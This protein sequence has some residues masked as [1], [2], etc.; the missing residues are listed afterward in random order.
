MYQAFLNKPW[1]ARWDDHP[2]HGTEATYGIECAIVEPRRH[3][4]LSGV[5]R[6]MS[7]MCPHMPL[8]IFHSQH[9]RKMIEDIVWPNGPNNIRLIPIHEQ[10]LNESNNMTHNDYNTLLTTPS[11]WDTFTYPKVLLFQTDTGI[12]KNEILRYYKY[13][14]IG[15][16]WSWTVAGQDNIHIGNGGLSLRS[17]AWMK[18]ICSLRTRD[19]TYSDKTTGE[20]EDIFYA[21]NMIYCEDIQLPTVEVASCFAVEH[22]YSDDPMGFHKA[23]DF[24]DPE[25]VEH[26]LE[27]GIDIAPKEIK[28][29]DS[30]IELQNGRIFEIPELTPWLSQGI[31]RSAFCIPKDTEIAP[32]K[33]IT[34]TF[35]TFQKVLKCVVEVEDKKC[36][37]SIPIRHRRA[38]FAFQLA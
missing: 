31:S 23:Y 13:D 35:P 12:R 7:H 20:P 19:D 16:P 9:N 29:H 33:S 30:W 18:R 4:N 34:D 2:A 10:Y 36:L 21:R 37:V 6:N 26:W 5:L 17:P 38:E 22:N 8:T 24:H 11:F 25:I 27:Q 32:F 28:L 14:Y 15:A 1:V 3:E